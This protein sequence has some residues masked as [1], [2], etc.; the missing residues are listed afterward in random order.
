MDVFTIVWIAPQFLYLL[1]H[2][3][4]SIPIQQEKI[5]SQ[6]EG[7]RALPVIL[8]MSCKL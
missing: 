8:V 5:V 6:L 1:S 3:K 2:K 4:V 7:A